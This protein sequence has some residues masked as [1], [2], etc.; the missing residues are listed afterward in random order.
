MVLRFTLQFCILRFELY[1]CLIKL[2]HEPNKLI[3]SLS[4]L[5]KAFY[6]II[7]PTYEG[8]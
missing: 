6:G 2:Y 7:Y 5:P 3:N 1:A 8:E 4:L